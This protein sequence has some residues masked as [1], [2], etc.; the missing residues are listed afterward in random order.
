MCV[1]LVCGCALMPR[2]ETLLCC[3]K[4]GLRAVGE[5]SLLCAYGGKRGVLVASVLVASGGTMT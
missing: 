1:E 4:H 2:K 5:Q 3:S